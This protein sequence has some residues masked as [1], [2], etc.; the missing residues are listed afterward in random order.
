VAAKKKR[1]QNSEETRRE[2]VEASMSGNE[3][4]EEVAKRFKIS[5]GQLYTWRM[6]WNREQ[7]KAKG[8]KAKANGA[9]EPVRLTPEALFTSRVNRAIVTLRQAQREVQ[10]LVAER[11]IKAPDKAHLLALLALLELQGD[12]AE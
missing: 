1:R 12:N 11:K 9:H 4:I 2:A 6:K 10:R 8:A 7:P 3:S 5:R